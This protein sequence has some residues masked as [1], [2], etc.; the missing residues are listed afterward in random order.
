M[1]KGMSLVELSWV[2]VLIIPPYIHFPQL[3]TNRPPFVCVVTL[4]NPFQRGGK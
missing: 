4:R 3:I 1:G 2:G